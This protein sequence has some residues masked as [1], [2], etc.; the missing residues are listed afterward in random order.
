MPV[1]QVEM[2]WRCSACHVENLGRFKG[3]QS[4]GK[5]KEGEPYYDAPG[6]ETPTYEQRVTDP[7]L[8]A[9]A[10]AGEDWSCRYCGSHQRRDNGTCAECGAGQAEAQRPVTYFSNYIADANR[11]RE[12]VPTLAP[13]PPQPAPSALGSWLKHYWVLLVV[14]AALLS[15]AGGLYFLLRTRVVTAEV[16][17]RTWEHKVHVD[18]YMVVEGQ[19]FDEQRPGTAF[20]IVPR[21]QRYHHT[22]KVPDGTRREAYTER[23]AC[24]QTCSKSPVSCTSNKNGFKTC[25]GGDERCTTK[26]CSETR[27]REVQKYRDVP[28]YEEW[29][30]WKN[31]EWALHR[32]VTEVGAFEEPS[33]PS[34]AKV[35]LNQGL[36]QGEKERTRNEARYHVVFQDREKKL[37]EYTPKDLEE[38]KRLKKGSERKVRVGI[39][40]DTTIEPY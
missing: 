19:G 12:E 30:S 38:F 23:V 20:D 15:I 2:R 35:R 5:A 31:W 32:T 3:C 37:H 14:G 28:V 10:T 36:G 17:E 21:G 25:S 22:N 24:G 40:R 9:Q 34:D 4:C 29:Y 6:T 8:I 27:Y 39:L 7:A 18:R 33:W 11:A 1:F 16:V 26:Y 13:P